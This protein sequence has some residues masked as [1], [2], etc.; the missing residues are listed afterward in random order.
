MTLSSN[1]TLCCR[2]FLN[3]PATGN[4]PC[5]PRQTLQVGME[6]LTGTECLEEQQLNGFPAYGPQFWTI[7]SY[8]VRHIHNAPVTTKCLLCEETFLTKV[9]WKTSWN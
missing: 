5:S 9:G 4:L 3:W 2:S 8:T 7:P 6:V 1:K